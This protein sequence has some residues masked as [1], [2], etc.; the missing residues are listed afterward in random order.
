[1]FLPVVCGEESCIPASSTFRG[2][3]DGEGSGRGQV[4]KKR[5]QAGGALFQGKLG[6]KK[7]VP[8]GNDNNGVRRTLSL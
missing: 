8:S 4:P 5:K 3:G 2:E 1:M 7:A 6:V